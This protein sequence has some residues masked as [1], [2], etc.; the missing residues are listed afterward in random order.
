MATALMHPSYDPYVVGLSLLIATYA[1]YVA[2]DVARRLHESDTYAKRLWTIGGGLVMGSGIWSM[3]FVGMLAMSLPIV[4]TYDPRLTVASWLAAVAV[5]AM[6]LRIASGERLVRRTLVAGGVG[7]GLGICAMHYIGMMA[8]RL[9]PAVEWNDELVAVSAVIAIGASATSLLIFFGLR[10][11]HG[12]RRA[13]AQAGAAVVMGVA[14]CGMHYTGMAAASFPASAHCITIN[15]LGGH[16]LVA[17]VVLANVVLL[18]MTLFTSVIDTRL[19]N[20]AQYLATSLQEANQELA[21]ANE[22]LQR[23]AYCDLLTGLANRTLLEERL[24]HALDKV[25]Q[26]MGM[27]GKRPLSRAALLFIDLD[28][29]K[30]VND[31]YGHAAGDEVLRQVAA[32]LLGAAR[33]M[34]TVARIGGDEF[35]LL[36]EDV[37]GNADAV[38]MAERI[39]DV[40]AQPYRFAGREAA[41]S[42]SIGLAL[43]PEHGHRTELMLHADAA[44][45]ASKRAG[46]NTY[47]IYESHMHSSASEQ[48]VVQQALRGAIARNELS[49]YYQPKMSRSGEQVGMEALL[50]WHHPELGEVEPDVFIPL[51]ERFGLIIAMG[52]WVIEE[53]CR[54]LSEWRR[55]GFRTRVAI[56]LSAYQLRQPDLVERL[57][58]AL[59]RHGV[60]P[61]Q[62]ECEVTETVAM[63]DTASSQRIMRE[64]GELGVSLSIDDFGTGYSSLSYLRQLRVHQLKIDRSFIRDLDRS[65]DAYAV[66]D[67]VIRLAH[68]LGL[69]VVAEGVETEAQQLALLDM[70]CDELQGFL[71]A[72]PAPAGVLNLTA[73]L[74]LAASL[75]DAATR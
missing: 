22:A 8:M 19:R 31:S 16:S 34:D 4:V 63:E 52:D 62:L 38:A 51:A 68:S 37:T 33:G 20:R 14:I 30:P 5:S 42:C 21:G 60:D 18:S 28:G 43:Y 50:R 29:F 61:G 6:S 46:G 23:M 45:Y 24:G 49:L 27:P 35:V 36:L 66:V 56:N 2:L 48:M 57:R 17:M 32:R 41:L 25:D 55:G 26:R 75:P 15:G 73:A 44:M 70:G 53:A 47:A 67:A 72:R 12:L 71:F 10:R 54:Q 74:P 64:L 1:S 39:L 9:V 59:A 13:Q 3:H 69:K 7:M 11:L 58:A 65:T 40:L